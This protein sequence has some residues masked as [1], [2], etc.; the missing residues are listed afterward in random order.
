MKIRKFEIDKPEDILYEAVIDLNDV[1]KN[2]WYSLR[3]EVWNDLEKIVNDTVKNYGTKISKD[4]VDSVLLGLLNR[5]W[6]INLNTAYHDKIYGGSEA[7][8]AKYDNLLKRL[9]MALNSRFS[10]K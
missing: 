8:K 2:T 5:N 3:E 7:K 9:E 10:M 6:G 1:K 4:D